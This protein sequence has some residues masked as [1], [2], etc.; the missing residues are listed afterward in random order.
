MKSKKLLFIVFLLLACLGLGYL[1]LQSNNDAQR[2]ANS[3]ETSSQVQ[4]T[5]DAPKDTKGFPFNEKRKENS[6]Y[7]K[8]SLDADISLSE[9]K[10]AMDEYYQSKYSDEEKK[11]AKQTIPNKDLES[12]QKSFKENDSLKKLKAT[13]E[14]VEIEIAGETLKVARIVIPF[15]YKE[16]KQIKDNNDI[17]VLNEALAQLGNHLIMVAYYNNETQILTPMHLTNSLNPLF[18]N[19]SIE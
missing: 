13:V 2:P 19:E 16:A 10:E 17:L 5:E 7:P 11:L 6:Q 4:T 15:T 18:Y 14:P 8:A 12:L 1:Y 9:L 3:P